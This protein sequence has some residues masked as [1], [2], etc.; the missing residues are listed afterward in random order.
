MWDG[1][2]GVA[3]RLQADGVDTLLV[4]PSNGAFEFAHSLG[5]GISYTVI[6]ASS[7][8]RHTCV[9]DGNGNGIVGDA[10]VA[11]VS[12][13]CTGPEVIVAFPG[14]AGWIFDPSEDDQKF[15]GPMLDSSVTLHLDGSNLVEATIDQDPVPLREDI[16]PVGLQ[17]G[18]TGVRLGFKASG[19]LS[20]SYSLHFERGPGAVDEL[21]F[22]EPAT[23]APDAHFGQAVAV[24]F[25]TLVVGAP[26]EGSGAV[27]V[28]ERSG[29]AWVQRA[30]LTS[31]AATSRDFGRSVALD[32]GTLIVGAPGDS[33]SSKGING[34]PSN[35]DAPESGAVYVF[36]RGESGWTQQVYIKA[37]NGGAFD[38]FGTSVALFRDTLAVGAPGESS[39]ATGGNLASAGAAYVFQREAAFWQETAYLKASNEDALDKFGTSVAVSS[40]TVVV[41][42]PGEA[43]SAP[44]ISGNPSDNNSP[45]AG[46]IYVF[47]VVPPVSPPPPGPPRPPTWRQ[48]AYIKASNTRPAALFGTSVALSGDTIAVGSI[49]ETSN[50]TGVNGNQQPGTAIAAG[51]VYVF[52]RGTSGWSQEAYLKASNTDASDQF[53]AS[54]AMSGA[55]LG[56][57]AA[58]E[59]SSGHSQSDDSAPSA[60]AVYLFVRNSAGW[61]QSTYVKGSNAG[62]R[63]Q[64]GA[65]VAV[66]AELV[67]GAP[68]AG[69]F[70][71]FR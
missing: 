21:A 27:Y 68:G 29:D 22:G 49:G 16:T 71:V 46:A 26:T 39:R 63:D 15:T 48:K 65:S 60:G 9:V 24:G 28:F 57:G 56:V 36:V 62:A 47:E 45:S 7:P 37:S 4:V 11:E 44:G 41:G 34:D 70:Y 52:V 38:R 64:F 31:A 32:A 51:A 6:V 30:R 50:A 3:L 20:R 23:A 14:N 59:A 10:D 42:S 43:S 40:S 12:I 5:T 25:N 33:S 19:G 66:S 1:A 8:A 18:A 58:G 55:I 69:A 61:V 35:V 67:V 54:V 13:L 17:L 53:G 2:D